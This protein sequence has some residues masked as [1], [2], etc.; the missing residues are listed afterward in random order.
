M[1]DKYALYAYLL[2]CIQFL[3]H[4]NFLINSS[5]NSDYL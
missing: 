4:G 5:Y 2:I 1:I 3:I